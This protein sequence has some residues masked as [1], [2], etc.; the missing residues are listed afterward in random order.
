MRSINRV[1]K[2]RY[3]DQRIKK[4]NIERIFHDTNIM[5]KKKEFKRKI[6]KKSHLRNVGY[7]YGIDIL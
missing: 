2:I 3:R 6:L 5:G 1:N 4:L 7:S